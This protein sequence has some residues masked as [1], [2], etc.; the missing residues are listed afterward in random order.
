MLPSGDSPALRVGRAEAR[1]VTSRVAGP[2]ASEGGGAS[3][4]ATSEAAACACA[5]R[6]PSGSSPPPRAGSTEAS[7]C[8]T[9]ARVAS[10]AAASPSS[11]VAGSACPSSIARARSAAATSEPSGE[12]ALWR[13]GVPPPPGP[14]DAV[15]G[16]KAGLS[17]SKGVLGVLSPRVRGATPSAVAAAASPRASPLDPTAAAA[18]AAAG[19]MG[20]PM[21]ASPDSDDPPERPRGGARLT[22]SLSGEP[23]TCAPRARAA[24]LPPTPSDRSSSSGEAA[25]IVQ[26]P[27]SSPV[28]RH[29]RALLG[30]AKSGLV[31]AP[32][33]ASPA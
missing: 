12:G 31:K 2:D 26:L 15:E 33:G 21:A 23:P 20:S 24:A 7:Q 10:R 5:A 8:A 3:S 28:S 13:S 11:G 4:T 27:S 1:G 25:A 18:T 16:A 6:S 29:C 14:P 9:D 32:P 19:A 17:T 30:V 22:L